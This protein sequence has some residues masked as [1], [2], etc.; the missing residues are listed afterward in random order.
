MP[1][2]DTI[3]FDLDGTLYDEERI[4]DRYAEEIARLLP[5][6]DR[7]EFIR[8][9]GEMK[10]GRGPKIVGLGYDISRRHL[11]RHAGGRLTGYLTWEGEDLPAETEPG[12]YPLF[13]SGRLNVGDSWGLLAALAARH[14]LPGDRRQA[15]F[16]ATRTY[17]SGEGRL[18]VEPSLRP[19][20]LTLREYGVQLIAMSNSPAGSVT[21][22]FDQLGIGDCFSR[23]I[24]DAAKPAGLID[25]LGT[26]SR[27]ER[28][29]SVGD[30]YVN[31]IEPALDAGAPALYID[32]HDTGLGVDRPRC[33]I[34]PSREE[35]WKHL[36][37]LVDRP[38][39]WR[40]HPPEHSES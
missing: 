31:D 2:I 10:S 21:D 27:A 20:L 26:L 22:T 33:T 32:R 23:I 37:T 39:A 19:S 36:R 35:A 3:I 6:E 11:F 16:V 28:T 9:W 30:N 1:A 17:M 24:P 40:L 18:Q 14:G 38:D 34:V 15:A 5:G 7:A 29:L 25:F 13:G 4:Y 8:E 12:S